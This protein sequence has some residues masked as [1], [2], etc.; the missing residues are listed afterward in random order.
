M[1]NSVIFSEDQINIKAENPPKLIISILAFC[2]FILGILPIFGTVL[3][4]LQQDGLKFELL[5]IYVI[6]WGSGFYLLR[7]LLWNLFGQEILILEKNKI[8]YFADY[9]LF[10][11]GRKEL[12]LDNLTSEI[13]SQIGLP[14]GEH[15]L[16][17][18]SKSSSIE[19]VLSIKENE[20]VRIIEK[21][22]T[23]YNKG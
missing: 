1:S 13:I 21:I 19:T 2:T 20:I 5:L 12:D 11:D 7:I 8:I 9:R 22:N 6:F 14:L 17:L 16:R 15:K 18:K 23:Y 3:L 10:K 4:I